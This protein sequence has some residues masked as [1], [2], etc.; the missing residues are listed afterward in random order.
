MPAPS[1]SQLPVVLAISLA[2]HVAAGGWLMSIPVGRQFLARI[3]PI[4]VVEKPKPLTRKPPRRQKPPPPNLKR[5]ARVA[6]L[7]PPPRP[8]VLSPPGTDRIAGFGSGPPQ[9]GGGTLE[10]PVG[11]TI[12][13]PATLSFTPS[14]SAM[15]SPLILTF[16]DDAESAALYQLPAPI[17][18][19]PAAFPEIARLSGATGSALVEA[20]VQSDGSV[21]AVRLVH[22]TSAPFGKAATAAV[23]LARFRPATRSGIP[24]ACTIRLPINFELS[25][26]ETAI[27]APPE[28]SFTK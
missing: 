22:A 19:L 6:K 12:E 9:A 18:A 2:V 26:S 8:A 15:P 5:A 13:T 10:V 24:V 4:Q 17:G 1:R 27:S 25:A 7:L 20:D 23:R 14:A 16:A 3:I 21:T 28:V 11:E